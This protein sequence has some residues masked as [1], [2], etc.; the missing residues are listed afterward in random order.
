MLFNVAD[1]SANEVVFCVNQK[2]Q[3]VVLMNAE[4]FCGEGQEEYV[5]TSGSGIERPEDLTPL[6]VFSD[7]VDFDCGGGSTGTTTQIGLDKN[8]DGKLGDDEV[9]V[10]SGTCV[11]SDTGL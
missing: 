1:S 4:G 7:N 9:M 5:V 6:A 11:A 8:G 2:D 10:I 3:E